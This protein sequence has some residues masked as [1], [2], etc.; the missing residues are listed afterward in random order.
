MVNFLNLPTVQAPRNA[1]ADL[2]PIGN[3][4]DGN[5]RNA[6]MV[7]EGQRQDKELAMR[8]EQLDQTKKM[9][10]LEYRSKIA[11]RSAGI[12]QMA[13]NE[14]D[15]ARKAAI[16]GNLYSQHPEFQQNLAAHGIDPNDHDTAAKFVIAEA[17]GY[18]NP[19]DTQLKQLQIQNAQSSLSTDALQRKQLQM[20]IDQENRFNSMFDGADP[21]GQ[22]VDPTDATGSFAQP[23]LTQQP[24]QQNQ[25]QAAVAKLSPEKQVAFKLAWQSGDRESAIKMIQASTDGLG[26]YKGAK[27]VSDVEEGLRKEYATIAKPYFELRDAYSRISQSAKD[28][29]AAGDLAL[30]FNYMKMLDPGSVVREGEFATAQNAAGV[31]D[32]IRN[33]A[34]RLINGERLNESQRKDFVTQSDGLM[35]RQERQYQKIQE[36]YRGIATRRQ[37]D[38]Q[39][40]IIDFTAPPEE[41]APPPN[42]AAA[43]LQGG[44]QPPPASPK[45]AEDYNRLPPGSSYVDPEGNIRIK[46]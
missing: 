45:S 7:Q 30:I 29:S 21:T 38:P 34:N 12:M 39:N 32:R 26:P 14:K 11:Q 23:K 17:R 31:P 44:A 46:Q 9:T 36:Q 28:P 35:K 20:K 8:R 27:E 13:M 42:A 33:M 18:V 4:I 19:D 22:A 43:Q 24:A 3:A 10:D 6:L 5:R 37:I 15:P 25:L 40:V 16:V 2:S 1:L 41:S